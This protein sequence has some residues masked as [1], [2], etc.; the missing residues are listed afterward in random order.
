MKTKNSTSDV[1]Y[2]IVVVFGIMVIVLRVLIM[3]IQLFL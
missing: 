2:T 3:M 1:F